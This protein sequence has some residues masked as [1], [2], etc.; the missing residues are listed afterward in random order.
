MTG[1]IIEPCRQSL[2]LLLNYLFVCLFNNVYE[3]FACMSTYTPHA[4]LM[5]T[6]ARR[7]N[8]SLESQVAESVSCL[9][10]AGN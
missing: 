4:W 10:G 9:V 3:C 1:D 8:G 6:K 5:P 2:A 7:E